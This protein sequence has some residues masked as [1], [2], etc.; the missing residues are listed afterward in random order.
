MRSANMLKK[1]MQMHLKL[2]ANVYT[3]QFWNV[4]NEQVN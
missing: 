1:H 4:L 2:T 3:E